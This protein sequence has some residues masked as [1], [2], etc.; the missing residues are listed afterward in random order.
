MLSWLG[1]EVDHSETEA[2]RLSEEGL[3]PSS[4]HDRL[5]DIGVPY[6]DELQGENIPLVK[7]ANHETAV[8]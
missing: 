7:V 4:E 3:Y 6:C 5:E 2:S 8:Q 1:R